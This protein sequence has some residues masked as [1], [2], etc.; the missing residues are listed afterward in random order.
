MTGRWAASVHVTTMV[1]RDLGGAPIWGS[2]FH[3]EQYSARWRTTA[4]HSS[5]AR[6]HLASGKVNSP[7]LPRPRRRRPRTREPV[8]RPWHRD[9]ASRVTRKQAR[10]ARDMAVYLGE[11]TGKGPALPVH[12]SRH[13]TAHSNPPAAPGYI[14]LAGSGMTN[15]GF[16]MTK[17]ARAKLLALPF[18]V[19]KWESL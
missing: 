14:P 5:S 6:G 19:G 15:P 13:E 8:G 4:A 12:L 7:H 16:G 11:V 3:P 1:A 9:P 17:P 18:E 10:L 2:T